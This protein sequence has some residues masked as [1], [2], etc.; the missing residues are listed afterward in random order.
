MSA[1]PAL[2]R[3]SRP[4]WWSLPKRGAGRREAVVEGMEEIVQG[5]CLDKLIA[6]VDAV[7]ADCAQKQAA[8]LA[9][10]QQAVAEIAAFAAMDPDVRE[11]Q[12]SRLQSA[13][14]RMRRLSSWER[15]LVDFRLYVMGG[16]IPGRATV[17]WGREPE[18]RQQLPREEDYCWDDWDY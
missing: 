13:A 12:A 17:R 3:S 5:V 18:F 10:M 2:S 8:C 1:A 9:E 15:D 6:N 4:G 7:Q 14:R 16:E 11:I